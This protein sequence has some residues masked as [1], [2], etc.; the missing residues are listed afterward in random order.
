MD[1]EIAI[2]R[3]LHIVPGVVWVGTAI[4]TAWVMSPA[5]AKTGPPHAGAVMSNMVKPMMVL[6]HSTAL[7]TIVFGIVMAFRVRDPLFDFLW[8]TDWGTMIWLG[9]LLAIV[10]YIIGAI[11]GMTMKKMMD[12]GASLQ[13]PPTPEQAAQMGALQKR[14]GMLTKLASAIVLVAVVCMAL[15][16]HI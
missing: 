2:L 10:G 11:G 13:G 15:A 3:I 9:A 16:N 5:V 8:S 7:F 1:A 4:F 6:M 14:G 12:M